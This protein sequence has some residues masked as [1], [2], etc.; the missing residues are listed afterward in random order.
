M[1]YG[2]IVNMWA[3]MAAAAETLQ[4]LSGKLPCKPELLWRRAVAR[5][6]LFLFVLVYFACIPT[7]R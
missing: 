3:G 5:L 2:R 6:S 1:V 7:R 4:N